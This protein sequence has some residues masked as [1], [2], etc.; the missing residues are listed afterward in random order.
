VF[1][2]RTNGCLLIS[3][4]LYSI[5]NFSI[6]VV[7]EEPKRKKTV[8]RR[9]YDWFCGFDESAEGLKNIMQQEAHLK[10]I[11]ALKQDKRAK[12]GLNFLL[13]IIVTIAVF[14]YGYFS[15]P[16]MPSYGD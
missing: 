11:Q 6:S 7:I 9:G 14:L 12:L 10:G 1:Q 8:L 13:G 4:Y 15:A 5:L 2:S 16:P 3:I